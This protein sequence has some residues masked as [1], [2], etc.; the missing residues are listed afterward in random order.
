MAGELP[1][2]QFIAA[3]AMT[4]SCRWWEVELGCFTTHARVLELKYM[5]IL[6]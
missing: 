4:K 2:V 5:C 1:A 6:V 3:I